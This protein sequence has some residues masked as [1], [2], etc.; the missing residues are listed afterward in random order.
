MTEDIALSK[1]A[2]CVSA[3]KAGATRLIVARA[4]VMAGNA[5]KRTVAIKAAKVEIALEIVIRWIVDA[6]NVKMENA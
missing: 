6:R 5:T 4:V 3:I 1:T 2:T